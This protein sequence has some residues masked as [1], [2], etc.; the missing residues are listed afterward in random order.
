MI[1][2]IISA[3]IPSTI[4]GLCFGI[5]EYKAKKREDKRI[6]HQKHKEAMQKDQMVY[7]M[8]QVTA[9]LA[10]SE[11]TARAVQRIPD[12]QCN[13]DMHEALKFAHKVKCDYKDF[14]NKLAAENLMEE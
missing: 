6:E 14:L 11:A 7:M 9:S 3:G 13:G 12:A 1:E 8:R 10:L 5:L 2:L 4:I